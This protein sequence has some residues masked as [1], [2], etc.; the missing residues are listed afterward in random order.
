VEQ[1]NESFLKE[2]MNKSYGSIIESAKLFYDMS[3]DSNKKRS[4]ELL[5]NLNNYPDMS[6]D[7]SF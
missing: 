2:N 7:V 3:P 5:I 4:L 1:L 6:L